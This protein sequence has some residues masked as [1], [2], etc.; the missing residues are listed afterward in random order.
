M[1]AVAW[2]L[3]IIACFRLGKKEPKIK[4][5]LDIGYNIMIHNKSSKSLHS[6]EIKDKVIIG[7]VLKNVPLFENVFM[8]VRVQGG[9]KNEGT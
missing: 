6:I 4:L 7:K 9:G 1:V 8:R 3:A 5:T 2:I